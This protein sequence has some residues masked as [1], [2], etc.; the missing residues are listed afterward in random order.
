MENKVAIQKFGR[1]SMK[2]IRKKLSVA[3]LTVVLIAL[4]FLVTEKTDVLAANPKVTAIKQTGT[5]NDRIYITWNAPI[6]ASSFNVYVSESRD[7]PQHQ[8]VIE[9]SYSNRTYITGLNANQTYY[10]KIIPQGN[11][12]MYDFSDIVAC[13]TAPEA[14]TNLRHTSSGTSS[15]SVSWDAPISGAQ[16]YKI[17]YKLSGSYMKETYAGTT[18]SRSYTITKLADDTNYNIYVYP[19]RK[20]GNGF[21]AMGQDGYVPY[22]STVAK[23]NK[24]SVIK[25]SRY[26]ASSE[27]ATISFT[28]ECHNQSGIEVEVRNLSG[29]KIKSVKL[30]RYASYATFSSSSIKNKGFQYRLRYYVITDSKYCYGPYTKT[31]VVIA[32]PKVTSTKK[33]NSTVQLKWNKIAKAKS[34]TVYVSKEESRRYKKVATVKSN[35]YTLKNIK[36]GKDYYIYVRANG[37]KSGK[38]SYSSTKAVYQPITKVSIYQYTK[39]SSNYYTT[40]VTE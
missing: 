27:T 11:E 31:K 13:S 26:A 1:I 9:K 34:Y 33:N 7:F 6:G 14:V 21:E 4:A 36:C 16:Y 8:T 37:V 28:N 15:I 32:H 5:G 2:R 29:K 22:A 25:L 39:S 18:T 30:S 35:A 20:S 17:Y 40:Y 24:F 12:G 19:V 38:K 3:M 23:A 10:V